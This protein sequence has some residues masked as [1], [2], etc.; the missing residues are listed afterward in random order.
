MADAH[1]EA[2]RT[3]TAGQMRAASLA[4][5]RLTIGL[6]DR[7]ARIAELEAELSAAWVENTALQDD[8]AEARA[9]LAWANINDF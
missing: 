5:R 9:A 1:E 7:D 3:Y 2:G 8:L 6:A 4:I